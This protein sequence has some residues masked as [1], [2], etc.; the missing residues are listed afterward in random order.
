MRSPAAAIM[1]CGSLLPP[2]KAAASRRTPKS[3]VIDRRYRTAGPDASGPPL[4]RNS[5]K[6]FKTLTYPL[7]V[8]GAASHTA[9]V[10]FSCE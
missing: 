5:N 8:F 1:E 6:I 3:A 7:M 10:F 2:F 9:T 4:Q